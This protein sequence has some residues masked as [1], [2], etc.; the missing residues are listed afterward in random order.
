MKRSVAL[1]IHNVEINS[2]RTIPQQ[3]G[4]HVNWIEPTR[5]VVIVQLAE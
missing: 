2:P 3:S 4:R 1:I 5:V